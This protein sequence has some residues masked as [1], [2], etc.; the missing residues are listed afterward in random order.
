M[1]RTFLATS[2]CITIFLVSACVSGDVSFADM[3]SAEARFNARQ[4]AKL[5]A[6]MTRDQM[7]PSSRQSAVARLVQRGDLPGIEKSLREGGDVNQRGTGKATYLYWALRNERA[8]S[9][10]KLLELGADPNVIFDDGGS[11]MH[12]AARDE[13]LSYLK[14]ALTHS[15]DPNLLAGQMR[16]TPAFQAI[17]LA[18]DSKDI[19]AIELLSEYGANLEARDIRG[20]TLSMSAAGLA[21]FDVVYFL[22]E[23]GI[24]YNASNDKGRTLMDL[25]VE[26]RGAFIPGSEKDAQL[27]KVENWLLAR[28]VR[29]VK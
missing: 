25:V 1:T 27:T 23:N 28:D 4:S 5:V 13:D 3:E 9:F 7:F 11:V 26:Y 29:I 16:T 6:Y 12:W 22:L 21:R 8:D 15:G 17:G 14:L 18:V 19:R 24:D 20:N 10:E 2:T